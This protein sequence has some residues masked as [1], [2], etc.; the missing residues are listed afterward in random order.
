MYVVPTFY[1][2]GTLAVLSS[3]VPSTF[4]K[5]FRLKKSLKVFNLINLSSGLELQGCGKAP[6]NTR[7]FKGILVSW[8]FADFDQFLDY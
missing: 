5:Y 3:N 8:Y 4:F 6:Q 7:I 2:T 1:I